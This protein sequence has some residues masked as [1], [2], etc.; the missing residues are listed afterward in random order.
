MPEFLEIE[1]YRRHAERALD[2][3]IARVHAED[4][5]FLKGGLDAATVTDALV[6]RRLTTAR[7]RGKLL[8]LDTGGGP[9]LG[10]RFGMTGRLVLDETA[11]LD[12]LAYGS[13]R[14][15]TA[16]DRFALD[17]ADG[18]HLRLRDPRRLGG[19]F[20]D[21]DEEVLGPDA[22]ALTLRQLRAALDRSTAPVKARLMDQHRIA[23][24]GNLLADEILWR[25]GID[26]ARPAGRLDDDE[27]RRLHRH[28]RSSLERMLTRGGSHTGDLQEARHRGGL[29]PR[30]GTPLLRRTIG[31]R[32]TYS[33]PE[34]Q[35]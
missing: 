20:L 6:G 4:A 28:L 13:N 24:L 9:V 5:W 32:T 2:R 18:G 21:P 35:R 12:D 1:F 34:H 16:W 25:A 30:D 19:V 29:C 8:L 11:A 22:L 3:E 27:V 33:C 26:P 15:V 31:G 7:R 23:G 14:D 17:F 10:L